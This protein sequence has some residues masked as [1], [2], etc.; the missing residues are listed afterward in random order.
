LAEPAAGRLLVVAGAIVVPGPP[1]RVLVAQRAHPPE[2]AGRWEFPGGKVEPGETPRD[3]LVRECR[4]E[5]GVRV[6]VGAVLGA[7]VALPG[8]R[9]RLFACRTPDVPAPL[10][11]RALALR[12]AAEL[13]G[14]SWLDTNRPL[15]ARVQVMLNGASSAG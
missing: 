3:A 7:D 10:E 2:L 8:G 6:E 4:E 13:P 12:T 5:L 14:L 1:D 11:H 15:L 9:L